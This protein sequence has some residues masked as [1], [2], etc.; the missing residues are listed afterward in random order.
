MGYYEQTDMREAKHLEELAVLYPVKQEALTTEHSIK[1][2]P[3][4]N[5]GVILS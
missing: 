3:I 1:I 4:P 5:C 2:S